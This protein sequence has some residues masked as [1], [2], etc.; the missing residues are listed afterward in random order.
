MK[1]LVSALIAGALFA[2][3]AAQAQPGPQR[4]QTTQRAPATHA[5]P[6]KATPAKATPRRIATPPKHWRK[7]AKEWQSHAN[8]CQKKYRTYNPRTDRYSY[9]G[10]SLQCRL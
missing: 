8:R 3:G 6:A 5:A 9:R 7:S 10:R 4:T 2:T 1:K